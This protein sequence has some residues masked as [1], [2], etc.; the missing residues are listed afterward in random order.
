[1]HKG[2]RSVGGERQGRTMLVR[3]TKMGI[4]PQT[5]KRT[6]VVVS[7]QSSRQSCVSSRLGPVP[8]NVTSFWVVCRCPTDSAR[9]TVFV[10]SFV[11]M[12]FLRC[13][14]PSTSHLRISCAQ[15]TLYKQNNAAAFDK[16][17]MGMCARIPS[18]IC[19]RSFPESMGP[20]PHDHAPKL[21]IKSK[22]KTLLLKMAYLFEISSLSRA[23]ERQGKNKSKT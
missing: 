1:M 5:C 20:L 9:V 22:T 12:N 10:F 23:R 13:V 14:H 18:L 21:F 3:A 11:F 2:S 19:K 17:A 4:V 8:A 15:P 16:V 6:M 7:A